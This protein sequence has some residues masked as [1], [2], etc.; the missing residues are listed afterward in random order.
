M[1]QYAAS[2]NI[3]ILCPK[4]VN[5]ALSI[6]FQEHFGLTSDESLKSHLCAFDIAAP[7]QEPSRLVHHYRMAWWQQGHRVP[8]QGCLHWDEIEDIV[9]DHL[10]QLVSVWTP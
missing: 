3:I 4:P 7:P 6:M 2:E 1:L 9:S 5:H 10:D 8:L